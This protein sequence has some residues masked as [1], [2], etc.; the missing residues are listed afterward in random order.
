MGNDDHSYFIIHGLNMYILFLVSFLIEFYFIEVYVNMNT[1]F[2]VIDI[3]RKQGLLNYL[4]KLS[5][6]ISFKL[7]FTYNPIRIVKKKK[8]KIVNKITNK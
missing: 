4:K 8:T 6:R 5:R 3:Y 1:Y 2:D 7:R